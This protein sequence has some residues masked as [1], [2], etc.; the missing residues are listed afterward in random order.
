MS[1]T[2]EKLPPYRLTFIVDPCQLQELADMPSVLETESTKPLHEVR[3]GAT[4]VVKFFVVLAPDKGDTTREMREEKRI[5]TA[6]TII[7]K[8][9]DLKRSPFEAIAFTFVLDP[10]RTNI[11]LAERL[12]LRCLKTRP[13]PKNSKT[14]KLLSYTYTSD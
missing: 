12:M 4:A 6:T 11:N 3:F 5:I 2:P 13:K 10:A 8:R 9:I 1:E 7:T 14:V